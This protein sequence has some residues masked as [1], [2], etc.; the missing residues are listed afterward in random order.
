MKIEERAEGKVLVIAIPARRLDVQNVDLFR[1][2]MA[3]RIEAGWSRFVLD[4][5]QVEYIDSSGLGA[6]LS[7]LKKLAG[8]GGINFCGLD[9]PV[10]QLFRMTRLDKAGHVFRSVEEAIGDLS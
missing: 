10:A 6:I 8:S 9:Q 2:H 7:L 1:E 4:L 3:A 5:S